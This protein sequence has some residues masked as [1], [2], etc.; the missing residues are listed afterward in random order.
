M[1]GGRKSKRYVVASVQ[2]AP[3]PSMVWRGEFVSRERDQVEE[4]EGVGGQGESC[5]VVS[6]DV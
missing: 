5:P 1:S 3:K 2:A 6:S 4:A